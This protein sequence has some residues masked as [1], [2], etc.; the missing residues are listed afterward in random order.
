MDHPE[1]MPHEDADISHYLTRV[2]FLGV[3]AP[4]RPS[5]VIMDDPDA[6]PTE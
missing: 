6:P 4:P 3:G 2:M 5:L 1:R